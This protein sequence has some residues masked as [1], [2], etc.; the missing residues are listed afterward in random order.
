[1]ARTEVLSFDAS[2]VLCRLSGIDAP[3]RSI[4]TVLPSGESLIS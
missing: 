3:F 4:I 1:M 2:R